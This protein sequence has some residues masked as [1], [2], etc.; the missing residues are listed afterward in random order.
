MFLGLFEK[1]PERLTHVGQAELVG[2]A[3]S[4]PIPFELLLLKVKVGLEGPA[5]IRCNRNAPDD[6]GRL[7]PEE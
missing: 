4:L 2:L 7:A 3:E 5:G 1:R 6:C